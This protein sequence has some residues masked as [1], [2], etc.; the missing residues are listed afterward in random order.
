MILRGEFFL[1]SENIA[2]IFLYIINTK[3]RKK[4]A[5]GLLMRLLLKVHKAE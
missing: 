4:S 2:V 3:E 5:L 1:G